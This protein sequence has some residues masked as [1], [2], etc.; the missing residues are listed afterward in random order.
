MA[1][2]VWDEEALDRR[3]GTF[4]L[5]LELPEEIHP[6]NNPDGSRPEITL[7]VDT[8]GKARQSLQ[9]LEQMRGNDE[10]QN[11]MICWDFG[12]MFA[13]DELKAGWES[14]DN[15]TAEQLRA[16]MNYV[17]PDWSEPVDLVKAVVTASEL[18]GG[19]VV[20]IS[21]TVPSAVALMWGLDN[22]LDIRLLNNVLGTFMPDLE[23]EDD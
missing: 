19:E 14:P 12:M 6:A 1:T 23:D 2:K 20:K 21:V 8:K 11:A 17:R 5:M 16:V 3:S 10:T 15:P 4:K 18:G 7:H 22:W 13:P 9:V